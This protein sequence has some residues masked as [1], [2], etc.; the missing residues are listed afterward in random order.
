MVVWD[1]SPVVGSLFLDSLQPMVTK[2]SEFLQK[3]HKPWTRNSKIF[4]QF[5]NTDQY[6]L[7]LGS[8]KSI[9]T[10]IAT[11]RCGVWSWREVW[12]TMAGHSSSPPPKGRET[13]RTSLN[14][15]DLSLL[16]DVH[17]LYAV[18]LLPHPIHRSCTNYCQW[19]S[20]GHP[21]F[22][23]LQQFN[24]ACLERKIE[25]LGLKFNFYSIYL[26]RCF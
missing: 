8:H 5:I 15:Q 16:P 14:I 4:S 1:S 26:A 9:L 24:L 11:E 25:V 22:F 23:L 17:M 19:W 6:I 3:E 12:Q 10:V 20:M 7:K 2:M 13:W 18:L 21:V